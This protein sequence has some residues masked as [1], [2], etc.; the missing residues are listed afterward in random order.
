MSRIELTTKVKDYRAIQSLIQELQD[1]ADTIKAAI[2]A[3]MERQGADTLQVDV[4]TVRWTEYT[5]NRVDTT[6]LKKA[7]PDLAEQFT[8]TS[9]SRRFQVA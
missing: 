9:T 6:A 2:T 5:T 7:L 8:K 1:E 3:E 4:F